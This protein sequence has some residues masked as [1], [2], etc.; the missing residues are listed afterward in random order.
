M[1]VGDWVTQN[2]DF[3]TWW[4]AERFHLKIIKIDEKKVYL[5]KNFKIDSAIDSS[6][7]IHECYLKIDIQYIR[8]QKLKKLS[9]EKYKGNNMY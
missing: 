9:S 1:K 2:E 7:I 5:H 4:K 6:N 8:K 3:Y